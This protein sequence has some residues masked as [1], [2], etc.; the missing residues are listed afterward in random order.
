[1]IT[2][3][4]EKIPFA[5]G[6]RVLD[7]GCGQG[8]HTAAVCGR[9]GV[10]CIGSDRSFEDLVKTREKLDVHRRMDDFSAAGAS[11]AASDIRRLP[12][13]EESFDTVICSEVLEHIDRDELA[14]QELLRVLKPGK[15]LAVSIPKYAPEK[16]CWM[17][18]REYSSASGGHI[19]IYRKKELVAMIER[20]GAK[21]VGTGHA[22]SLHT[23]FWWLKCLVGCNRKDSA[24]VNLYHRFLVWDLMKKPP[25]TRTVEK[26]LDPLFGKSLVLY[27]IK[28]A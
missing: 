15:I 14:I 13:Q 1:M 26:L 20:L 21:H 12:F 5:P 11:L 3:D 4:L 16:L 9:Q 25:V 7:M 27:F 17:L 19:R 28:D 10:W 23:P 8:R 24:A 6:D 22:H 18:S 2:I